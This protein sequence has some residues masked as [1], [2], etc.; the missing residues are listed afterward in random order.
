MLVKFGNIHVK[1]TLILVSDILLYLLVEVGSLQSVFLNKVS[2][3]LPSLLIPLGYNLSAFNTS[4]KLH[5][6]L[7]NVCT[8]YG[9]GAPIYQGG[10]FLHSCWHLYWR[11]R[12]F[13]GLSSRLVNKL[14]IDCVLV[15]WF[16]LHVLRYLILNHL[17]KKI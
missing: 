2:V 1:W 14:D 16:D 9:L 12:T 6:L 4:L 5:L 7:L 13:S 10:L 11:G 8:A 3:L 17:L 15:H